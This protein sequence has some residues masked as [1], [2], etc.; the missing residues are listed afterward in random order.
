MKL[1]KLYELAVKYG[2]K[3]DP[4]GGEIAGYFK[5]V[6]NK[7]RKLKAREKLAFDK[8]SFFNPFSDTRI[9][10][11]APVHRGGVYG[12]KDIEV[13][14]I[15]VGIDIEAPEILLADKIRDRE[16]LDLVIAH[17]PE[18]LAYAG[19]SEVMQ[20]HSFILQKLGLGK[21]IADS[22]VK[23]RMEEVER[24]VAPANHSRATD[25]AR[26]LDM[27][28]MSIH[29]PADNFV[30]KYLQE[31]LDRAKP[32]K[33]NDVLEILSRIPEYKEALCNKAG[34]KIILGKP[35]NKAGKVFVDMTGGT[36]GPK[37]L[38]GRISQAGV[39]T[40]VSMHLSEEHFARAKPE[41]INFIIAGHIASDNI[42]LNLILDKIESHEKLEIIC[43]S[44]FK[45]I[46]R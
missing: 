10:Y 33:V 6:K 3:Q 22:S 41:H 29:T 13:K 44:G 8:E 28:F 9:L 34:P 17:H 23:E 26:L 1:A 36:E 19:L 37:E 42:G 24:K 46:R 4:R 21:E 40:V 43:C 35:E 7:Y 18:G 15:L 27:P 2:M 16:G 12:D 39:E 5:N 31:L 30:V 11:P 25:A 14:K 38:F 32:K 45:R 20:V